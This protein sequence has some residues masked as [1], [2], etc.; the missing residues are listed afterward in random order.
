MQR[1]AFALLAAIVVCPVQGQTS[2]IG[3]ATVYYDLERIPHI[4]SQ[5]DVGAM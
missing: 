1:S 4:F 3:N 5:T 2:T